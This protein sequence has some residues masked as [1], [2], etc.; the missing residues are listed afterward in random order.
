MGYPWDSHKDVIERLYVTDNKKV[1]EIMEYM[2]NHH[3]FTPRYVVLSCLVFVVLAL[4]ASF[5]PRLRPV[6]QADCLGAPY[7]LP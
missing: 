7:A 6:R 5:V 3:D 1:N 2:R 4:T